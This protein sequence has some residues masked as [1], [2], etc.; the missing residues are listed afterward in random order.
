MLIYHE[1]VNTGTSQPIPTEDNEFTY[2]LDKEEFIEVEEE[3]IQENII[4]GE[5]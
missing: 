4:T 5:D 2:E 1:Y 3:D